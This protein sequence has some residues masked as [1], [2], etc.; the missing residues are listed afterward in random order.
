MSQKHGG[1]QN[2]GSGVSS[3]SA[4]DVKTDVSATGLENGM[5][6]TNVDT[7]D[8]TGATNKTGTDVGK[9]G[10][11]K[12]RGDE[13]VELLGP[14]DSLHRGVVDN[15]VTVLD[16]G[17]VSRNLL[18][19]VSEETIGELHNVGLV[20]GGNLV[21]VVL[22]SK[23]KGESGNSLGLSL[24]DDL[25][26]LN[27]T[28]DGGVLETGV[29]TL[30]VLSD[31]SHVNTLVSGLDTGDV[32]DE[33]EGSED[34]KLSSKGDVE[35]LV[36]VLLNGSVEDTLDGNLVSVDGSNG[37]LVTVEM[38]LADTGDVDNLPVNRDRDGLEDGLHGVSNLVTDT[39][40][41]DEGN[42]VLGSV[43]LGLEHG[44]SIGGE[45]SLGEGRGGLC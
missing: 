15:H 12:V 31:Q 37:L 3:T 24:G 40:T 26:G 35:R 19:G 29:L 32:L 5:L 7:G 4:L 1:R 25:D 2:H 39:I 42:S 21:S 20:D 45:S 8:E 14:R 17:V 33:D 10:T 22:E 16:L 34:I 13:D 23:V 27:D 9:N 41:G 28:G 11:V 43:L 38:V 44:S 6:G 30:S 18:T 36:A